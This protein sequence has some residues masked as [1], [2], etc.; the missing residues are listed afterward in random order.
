[1]D[2]ELRALTMQKLMLLSTIRE[3]ELVPRFRNSAKIRFKKKLIR[4]NIRA[5]Q[6]WE[7]IKMEYVSLYAIEQNDPDIVYPACLKP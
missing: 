5:N 3:L 6:D 4:L 1:M 7:S 2:A